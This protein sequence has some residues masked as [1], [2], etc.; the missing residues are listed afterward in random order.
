M[1]RTLNNHRLVTK[2]SALALVLLFFGF[3]ALCI[4]ADSKRKKT[5]Q[6]RVSVRTASRS[7]R[8][9]RTVSRT[10]SR[11]R[12]GRRVVAARPRPNGSSISR[13]RIIEI[14]ERLIKAGFLEGAATGEYDEATVDAMKRFQ[15]R[16]RLPSTG[17]PS[18]L[19]LAKL[20]VSK[21]SNDGYAV[22]IKALSDTPKPVP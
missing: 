5:S 11:Q 16:H 14:Q 18:A 13:E 2:L 6:K 3:D 4:A 8:G 15:T 17:L 19:T 21:N 7:R 20:R 22:P 12:R 1:G 10:R 9:R